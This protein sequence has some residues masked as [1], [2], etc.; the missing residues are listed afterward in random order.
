MGECRT[1]CSPDRWQTLKKITNENTIT[2]FNFNP[3]QFP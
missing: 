3:I 2:T 1:V